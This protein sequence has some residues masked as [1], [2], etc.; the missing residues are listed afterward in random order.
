VVAHHDQS[1]NTIEGADNDG[2]GIATLLQLAAIFAAEPPPKYTLVFVATDAEEY[3]MIGTRRYIETHPA[4]SDIIAGISLDNLGKKWSNGM[5]MSPVGQFRNYGPLW[6]LLTTREAARADEDLWMPRIR[7]PLDQLLNQAVPVSFMDQGPLVAA[8]VPAFGFDTLYSPDPE[9]RELV[10]GTYHSPQDTL[11]DQ[12]PEVL[13]QSGRIS[14][15]LLRQLL[16]MDDFPQEGGPYLYFEA[17]Q[18][19]L[20]GTPLWLIF[21]GFVI[22]FFGGSYF[23]GGRLSAEKLRA[24]WGALPHLLSLWLPLLFSILL[25]YVFVWLGLMDKYHLYPALAKDS[26]IFQ[27]RWPA[28]ILYVIGLM[29]FLGA[30]HRLAGRYMSQATIPSPAQLKSLALLVV[31]LAGIYILIIN[32][33]S[34]LFFVPLLSWFF[35]GGRRGG[36]RLLDV[37]LFLLGGL[38]VYFLIYF[39]GFVILR[40]NFA[41]L[42]YLMMM[43]SIR[44]ISF[45]TA[46]AITAIL[47]AGLML[48][49]NLP[50]Q[51]SGRNI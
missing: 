12:S 26:A 6:L 45:P 3:G 4:P 35:I 25:L 51:A 13:H 17:S 27:P 16:A 20:R 23:S 42:W 15:A 18:R 30:G 32:P 10:W 11:D 21:I 47:A 8:G 48:V 49:V 41:V 37:T 36:G 1:P 24:W 50:L 40:N 9:I 22:L 46:V 29:A 2:S 33:F 31:G 39:F 44:M 5:D 38:V 19:V 34:L 7:S 43:F 28:V 14:E